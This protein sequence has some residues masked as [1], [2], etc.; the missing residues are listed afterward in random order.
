VR[1]LREDFLERFG[2]LR[3]SVDDRFDRLERLF[4]AVREKQSGRDRQCATELAE[5]AEMRRQL[6][7][8][9]EYLDGAKKCL[10]CKH[11]T[12]LAILEAGN[13]N[14]RAAVALISSALIAT[15]LKILADLL[16]HHAPALGN[17]AAGFSIG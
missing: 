11:Q 8:I 13:K 15:I 12:R 17:L 9:W 5:S 14:L 7:E 6:S 2:E 16:L 1:E 10:N 3:Q 4:E